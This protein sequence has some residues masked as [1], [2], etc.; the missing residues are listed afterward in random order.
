M[1]DE[2]AGT[3]GFLSS[4]R[5]ILRGLERDDLELYR[6]WLN[7]PS[8]THFMESGWRPVTDGD[9]DAI[10]SAMCDRDDSTVFI[11]ID[12]AL[13]RPVGVAGLYLI[14]WICRRA[15]FRI[16]IGDNMARG[17]GIGSDA[18]QLLVSYGFDKLNLE[19][20]YL[21]VN[22]ENI[23]AIKSYEKAGFQHE[24]RRRKLI[25]RN[26]R[27]YDAIMMSIIRQEYLE[28]AAEA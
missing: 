26:G 19:L 21:G 23:G 8:A 15:E 20:I 17:R 10:Y 27:Y 13:G 1:V 22:A 28:A 4:D 12:R 7:N 9:M 25:Y 24:G 2:A 11:I 16:L 14:Q 5:V 6:E 18:G 3:E